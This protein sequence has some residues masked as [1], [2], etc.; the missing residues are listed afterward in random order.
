MKGAI[1]TRFELR[2]CRLDYRDPDELWIHL[3]D[4]SI[5]TLYQREVI[6]ILRGYKQ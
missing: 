1:P 2:E 3:P 4:G 5:M 6:E